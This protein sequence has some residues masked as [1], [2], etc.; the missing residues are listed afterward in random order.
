[1]PASSLTLRLVDVRNRP[2]KEQVD[3]RL[4]R[5]TTGESKLVKT[6]SGKIAKVGKLA[7]D[8]YLVEADPPSYL[9]AGSF[10]MVPPGGGDLTIAFPV[11]PRK[12]KSVKFP[13]FDAVGTDCA[14]VL[15]ET[16]NLLGFTGLS[17]D[18]LYDA[19]DDTRRAGLLNIFCKSSWTVLTNGRTVA[20]Y[21]GQ[22]VELRGDR[23]HAVVPKELR[24]ETKN[25][26]QA[27]LFNEVPSSMH[28][29]PEGFSHAGSFKSQDHYGNIQ[30]TFFSN[31]PDW[32]AD[33]DID[34]ANGLAHVFQ[35]LRNELSG[36]PTHPYDIHEIL[37]KHQMLDPG[38]ELIV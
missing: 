27:G 36:R 31:G 15:D 5:Q 14:R 11:D 10:A 24:E 23:F 16:T 13:S 21:L 8:V 17:G 3:V 20:S 32:L 7:S 35:V 22:L 28:H 4:R 12:V 30:L 33:I 19:I 26:A 9:A 34:D 6:K 25:S 18:D 2:L 29:P 37:I 1:M 38:Y